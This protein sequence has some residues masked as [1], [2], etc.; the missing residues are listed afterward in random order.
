MFQ[1]C[2]PHPG[3]PAA[4]KVASNKNNNNDKQIPFSGVNVTVTPAKYWGSNVLVM[5][6]MR[7][8]FHSDLVHLVI[9]KIP[10][11]N[12]GSIN[13]Y[14]Y[15]K[16]VQ[17]QKSTCLHAYLWTSIFYLC[18]YI[19]KNHCKLSVKLKDR[20]LVDCVSESTEF[21]ASETLLFS[22]Q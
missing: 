21:S 16:L 3:L 19:K 4:L 12:N 5:H 17:L 15:A 2:L 9:T 18:G 8:G 10:N 6:L 14:V 1:R 7:G 11:I 20:F 13:M 22:P